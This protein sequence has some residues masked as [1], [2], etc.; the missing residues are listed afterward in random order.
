MSFDTEAVE[1]MCSS[2]K[3]YKTLKDART[4]KNN[5]ERHRYKKGGLRI[6]QCP[7][8]EFYHLTHSVYTKRT[9]N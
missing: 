2:K 8:C 3:Q 4:M 9:N 7:I 5:K 6:Y 1:R